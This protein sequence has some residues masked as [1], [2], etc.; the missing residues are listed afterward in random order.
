[1]LRVLVILSLSAGCITYTGAVD[2][3][4][5]TTTGYVVG[6][7]IDAA[8]VTGFFVG[9]FFG[10]TWRNEPLWQRFLAC[11]AGVVVIDAAIGGGVWFFKTIADAR[12]EDSVD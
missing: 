10:T 9:T 1:M 4:N 3:E 6:A 7:S 8:F 11:L 2:R 12:F 5:R